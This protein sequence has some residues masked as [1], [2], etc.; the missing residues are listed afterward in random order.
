LCAFFTHAWLH[1]K[2][3]QKRKRKFAWLICGRHSS[4]A[5]Y[6]RI[7]E[8]KLSYVYFDVWRQKGVKYAQKGDQK[9]IKGS[10]EK[11]AMGTLH[12]VSSVRRKGSGKGFMS[13]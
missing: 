3:L 2:E 8:N 9:K 6:A 13:N 10:W 1:I 12:K 7:R 4:R 5:I 11:G